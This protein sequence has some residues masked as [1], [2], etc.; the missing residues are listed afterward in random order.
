MFAPA[1]IVHGGAASW[2]AHGDPAK[3]HELRERAIEG[4][5]AAA[6]A[7]H[8]L[9][10][11][12]GSALD[13]VEVAVRALEDDETFN[14][15]YGAVL[16]RD[17]RVEHDALVVDGRLRAG[18]VGALP[19]FRNPV[20]IARRV[21][22]R[23]EHVLLVGEGARSFAREEAFVEAEPEALISSRARRR[24][25]AYL[26]G[27]DGGTIARSGDT[28][29]A[30]AIDGAGHVAAATSTGG[31]VGKRAGRVGDSPIVGA[32]GFADDRVGAVSATGHGESILRVSLSRAVAERLRAG[33]TIDA[34]C[35]FGLAEL[36]ER[37]GASAG[38]IAVGTDGRLA[39]ATSAPH[40]PWAAIDINGQRSGIE[41]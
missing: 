26:A 22:E 38:L 36:A 33:D 40:M 32:G 18:A 4:C 25:E 10:R 2:P 29:G 24:H 23:G 3:P 6:R 39:H 35:R 13:A 31:L 30:C 9:L 37:T 5:V 34:A 15:G 21:L 19:G 41:P 7:G 28:V 17:G 8:A 20:S 14:A 16:T 12:G 11:D 27:R 1:I